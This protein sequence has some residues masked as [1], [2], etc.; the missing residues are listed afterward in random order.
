MS[1]FPG[2]TLADLVLKASVYRHHMNSL[3][4]FE[5]STSKGQVFSAGP[6][7]IADVMVV[8]ATDGTILSGFYGLINRKN[9]LE[10]LGAWIT[11]VPDG[12]QNIH[13][14]VSF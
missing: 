14:S 7:G 9:C 11:G 4:R 8:V 1:C 5:L 12:K 13:F 3:R 6:D 2:E 10:A